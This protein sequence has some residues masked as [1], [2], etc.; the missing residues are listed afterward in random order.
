MTTDNYYKLWCWKAVDCTEQHNQMIVNEEELCYFTLKTFF[1]LPP[2]T[3]SSKYSCFLHRRW[4]L[5][6]TCFTLV[7]SYCKQFRLFKPGVGNL[8][9][10]VGHT[11]YSY[12][13]RDTQKEI[14][15]AVDSMR[16][17]IFLRRLQHSVIQHRIVSLKKTY[18]SEVRTDSIITSPWWWRQYAP[19]KRQ[20]ILMRPHGAVSQ[21]DVIF[22]F[23]AVK[24]SNLM[25]KSLASIKFYSKCYTF[26]K[27]WSL[28]YFKRRNSKY[29]RQT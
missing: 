16:N 24:S 2:N 7:Q 18:V 5:L 3:C 10:T 23:A 11:G 22:I 1:G 28:T 19:L 17:C 29:H 12:L 21:K 6:E 14:N 26:V 15:N 13:S 4:R 25:L 27:R 20:Y 9:I 8:F